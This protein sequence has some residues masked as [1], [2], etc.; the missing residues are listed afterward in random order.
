MAKKINKI[1][2]LTM[3]F[4]AVFGVGRMAFS[5]DSSITDLPN[6]AAI[7]KKQ[8]KVEELE[9]KAEAYRNI[10]E[11]KQKQQDTLNNQVTILEAEINKSEVEIEANKKQ[12]EELNNQ[13]TKLE[14]QIKEKENLI[15]VQKIYLSELVRNYYESRQQGIM[16]MIMLEN[17]EFTKI[18]SR[19]DSVIQIGE[20]VQEMLESLKTLK[21]NLADEVLKI[22]ENKKQLTDLHM[23]LEEKASKLETKKDQKKILILQTEGEESKYQSLLVRVEEQKKE[24]LGDIDE[25]YGANN[26]EISALAASLEKPKTG[27]ASLAWYYSQKDSRWGSNRIGQSSS[28]IKDYGCALTS[29]AM[30]YTF[31]G[32]STTPGTLARQKIFYWDLIVWPDGNNV[33]LAKNSSHGGISW[34]EVDREL[35][36]GNPVIVY[37]KAGS[38]GGHYVVI[39][40]KNSDGRYVVH[41]PYFGANI[42]LDSSMKLLSAL[43]NVAISKNSIDQMVVY[44]KK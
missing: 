20:K 12:I 33:K 24:L 43:Y 14:K 8:D 44:G 31:Y 15:I 4:V 10:I 40:H 11:I 18:L 38:K 9:E 7:E 27:T 23:D 32:E 2:I 3:I 22:N 28:L 35:A 26:V 34:S 5:D 42:Y 37:I 6:Q 19:E 29:V 1:L 13:I 21:N 25:L 41:D 30:V 16:P 36:K 39:H 17:N